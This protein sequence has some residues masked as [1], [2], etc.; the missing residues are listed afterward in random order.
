MPLL[1]SPQ[2]SVGVLSRSG[3]GGFIQN[4]GNP[5]SAMNPA[6]VWRKPLWFST[7]SMY[8]SMPARLYSCTIAWKYASVPYA[9]GALGVPRLNRSCT[10]YPTLDEAWFALPGHTYARLGGGSHTDPYPATK[11]SP[12]RRSITDHGHSNHCSV[13]AGFSSPARAIVH[14]AATPASRHSSEARRTRARGRIEDVAAAWRVVM[15]GVRRL[16]SV[17]SRRSRHSIRQ[18]APTGGVS[19]ANSS[20]DPPLG[21]HGCPGHR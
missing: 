20:H 18:Y 7:A 11:T 17:R 13:G 10:S 9:V 3:V 1:K 16:G 2:S 14:V 6:P 4:P 15:A 8:T 21:P 12:M 5:P 19:Q